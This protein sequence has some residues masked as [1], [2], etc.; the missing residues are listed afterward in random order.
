MKDSKIVS[1][2]VTTMMIVTSGI[3][4]ILFLV[5]WAEKGFDAAWDKFHTFVSSI[6]D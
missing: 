5:V 1:S 3:V 6:I 4:T 2:L